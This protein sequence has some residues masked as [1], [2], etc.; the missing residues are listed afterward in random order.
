MTL[1]LLDYLWLSTI[2]L[3]IALL[4]IA[5]LLR[6]ALLITSTVPTLLWEF[7]DLLPGLTVYVD[8]SVLTVVPFCNP[9]CRWVWSAV[10]LRVLLLLLAPVAALWV[11]LVST[12]ALLLLARAR[13]ALVGK[14][15]HEVIEERHCE[16]VLVIRKRMV[17]LVEQ[18][19][20]YTIRSG[21]EVM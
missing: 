7:V 16:G 21:G 6:V 9:G 14:L 11:A 10:V 4:R 18:L 15:V 2:S 3:L 8:P 12:I 13:A 20:K 1:L 19:A 5:L 17:Q